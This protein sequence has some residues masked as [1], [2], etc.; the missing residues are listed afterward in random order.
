MITIKKTVKKEKSPE[1]KGPNDYRLHGSLISFTYP[2][3]ND[4]ID[5]VYESIKA[6]AEENEIP[7]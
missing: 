4:N 7:L 1:P 2:K 3:C 6:K 5:T